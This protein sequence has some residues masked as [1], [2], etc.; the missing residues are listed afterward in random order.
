M[1][2][3]AV[4]LTCFSFKHEKN[5]TCAMTSDGVCWSQAGPVRMTGRGNPV[6]TNL[7]KG[8]RKGSR[9]PIYSCKLGLS[10]GICMYLSGGICMNGQFDTESML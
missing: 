9:P 10:G 3:F 8:H 2:C 6:K 5:C 1:S 7:P 4:S